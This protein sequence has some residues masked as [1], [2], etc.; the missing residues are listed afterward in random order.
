MQLKLSERIGSFKLRTLN[1]WAFWLHFL[2]AI[3]LVIYFSIDRQNVNINTDLY[4]YKITGIS[5][6]NNTDLTFEFGDDGPKI[7][8]S[9]ISLKTIVGLIFFI[10]ALFHL[11]YYKSEWYLKEVASGKNRL[12]WVEYGITASLMIFLF[13]IIASIKELYSTLSLV[14]FNIVLM[15]IGYFFEMSSDRP[16]K[17]SALIMGFFILTVTWAIIFGQFFPNVKAAKDDGVDIPGWVYGVLFPM[18]FAWIA[19]G[20]IAVLNFRAYQKKGYKFSRYEKYYIFLSYASK[21]FMGYYLA[22]G[23]TREASTKSS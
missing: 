19:F 17:L 15:S 5:G 6:S 7:P 13:A 22:F 9:D 11:Y 8:V 4:T 2:S 1:Y 3:G 14:C 18:F 23:L 10:T 21:A 12:R 16:V 20:V